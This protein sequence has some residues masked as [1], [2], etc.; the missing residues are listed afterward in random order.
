MDW[1][2]EHPDKFAFAAVLKLARMAVGLPDFDGG[3]P[4]YRVLRM[5][6]YWPF[7]VLFLLGAFAVLRQR[8]WSL[9]WLAIHLC[10]LATVITAVI[11]W[12]SARFRD[13]NVSILMLY[14]VVG[15]SW[16]EARH[17]AG[18]TLSGNP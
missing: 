5:A 7:L 4:L 9:P 10:I 18:V 11:F 12:G 16:I 14:E 1:I 6:G 2:R 3:Q 8:L 13:A 15:L 17:R